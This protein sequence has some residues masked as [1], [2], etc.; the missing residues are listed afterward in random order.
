[1]IKLKAQINIVDCSDEHLEKV[2]K[3]FKEKI[4]F[5]IIDNEIVVKSLSGSIEGIELDIVLSDKD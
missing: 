2:N 5:D 4:S 3:F 1:M